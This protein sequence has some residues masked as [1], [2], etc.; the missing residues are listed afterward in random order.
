VTDATNGTDNR[1]VDLTLTDFT[2]V[3]ASH[4][5]APGGG[6]VAALA[7]ALGAALA[8]MVARLTVYRERYIDHHDTMTDIAACA[9]ELRAE[10]LA[11]IDVDTAAYIEVIAA[12]RLPRADEAQ[13][14]ARAAAIQAAFQHAANIPLAVAQACAKVLELTVTVCRHGNRNASSDGVVAALMAQAALEGAV[15][16][17]RIN[18][19]SIKDARYC[20]EM[21]QQ[22]DAL[23]ARGRQMLAEAIAAA[24]AA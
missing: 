4:E 19:T 18:L 9:D 14:A 12:Y 11:Q 22:A 2:D 7:G 1:L 16:N 15:R 13:K 6:S 23:S 3:L 21:A 10:L 17:V 24:D 8:A 5:P 20:A